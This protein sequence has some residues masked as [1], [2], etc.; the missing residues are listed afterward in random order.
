MS[1]LW[2]TILLMLVMSVGATS[3]AQAQNS[4]RVPPQQRRLT[5]ILSKYNKLYDSAPNDIQSRNI[6]SQ[7]RRAFCS[8]IPKG[9][10]ADW[11]GQVNSI[12]DDNRQHGIQLIVEVAS[13]DLFPGSLGVELSL[14]NDYAYGVEATNT[15]HHAPTLIAVGS[16]LYKTASMFRSGDTIE[17]SGTFIPYISSLACYANDTTYFSLF[18]FSMI[19]KIG[20]GISF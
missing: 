17:F 14:G 3:W 16:P 5:D 8:A 7:F 4:L 1:R 15:Q 19:R 12:D 9:K 6:E 18:Q 2:P 11:I 10:V 20:W 13:Q